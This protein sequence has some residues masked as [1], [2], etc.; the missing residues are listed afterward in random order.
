MNNRNFDILMHKHKNFVSQEKDEINK[1][2]I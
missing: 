2:N 1:K